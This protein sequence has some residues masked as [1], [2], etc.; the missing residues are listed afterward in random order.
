VKIDKFH[1][2]SRCEIAV[3]C[4]WRETKSCSW[5]RATD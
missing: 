5:E 3:S 1:Q 2:G 4:K